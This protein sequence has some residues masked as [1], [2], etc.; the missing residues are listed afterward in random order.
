MFGCTKNSANILMFGLPVLIC[1]SLFL[2]LVRAVFKI[3]WF[4][5]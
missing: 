5:G 4:K 2:H 1:S 3:F